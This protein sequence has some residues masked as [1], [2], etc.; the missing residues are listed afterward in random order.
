MLV[1]KWIFPCNFRG[2][3]GNT[4][5]GEE[6]DLVS[7]VA[8]RGAGRSPLPGGRQRGRVIF[9]DNFKKAC[10]TISDLR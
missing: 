10:R 2:V 9:M 1:S 4:A 7:W 5:E 3:Q 8:A 6:T